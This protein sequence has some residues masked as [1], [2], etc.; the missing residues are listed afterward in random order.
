ME[1]LLE[2]NLTNNLINDYQIILKTVRTWPLDKRLILAQDLLRMV[3]SEVRTPRP[4]S[5]F[6]QALGLLATDEPPPTDEEVERILEEERMRKY[7]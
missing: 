4:Q 3:E 2:G 7:G 5:S 1:R 6:N